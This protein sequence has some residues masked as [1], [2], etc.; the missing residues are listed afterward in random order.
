MDAGRRDA[1]VARMERDV[2]VAYEAEAT[3]NDRACRAVD[4]LGLPDLAA[5]RAALRRLVARLEDATPYS[6]AAE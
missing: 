3:D 6:P 5:L 4:T 1:L 2:L